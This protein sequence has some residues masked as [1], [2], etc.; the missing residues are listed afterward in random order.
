MCFCGNTGHEE[1]KCHVKA[2]ASAEAQKKAKLKREPQENSVIQ[3]EDSMSEDFE[4]LADTPE[5]QDLL[6]T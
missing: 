3:V 2:K 5:I 4:H 1:A 6:I